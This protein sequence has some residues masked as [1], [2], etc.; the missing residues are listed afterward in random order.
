MKQFPKDFFWGAAT[1]AHQVEGNN[2]NNWS[3][4]ERENAGRLAKEAKD[5]WQDWQKEKFPEMF[6]PENY[7]SGRA[8][9]HYNRYEEDFD[10]AQSSGHNAHRFSIE[11]SRIE[12]EEGKFNEKE[13]EHY[14]KVILALRKRNIEPFATLW[15]WT[16]PL[17]LEEKGGCESKKFP[18]FFSR[19]AQYVVKNLGESVKF[20]ITLNEPTSVIAASYCIGNWP[21]QKKNLIVAW[22][23]YG[24]FARAHI[25]AYKIIRLISKDARVGFAN[26]L[27]SFEPYRKNSWLDKLSVAVGL[28]F[29]NKRMLNLTK[30]YNDFLTVQ[31]YFHNR[32]KFPRKIRLGDKPVNDLNWEIYPEGLYHVL[33][34]LKEY[35]LP[36]YVTENGLADA[37]EKRADFIKNHLQWIKKAIDEG[38]DVRGYFYWSLMDNF[39]WDKGFWP[40]FGLVEIDY[41]TLERKPRKSFYAYEEIIKNNGLI[42][43]VIPSARPPARQEAEESKS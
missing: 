2:V 23:L 40:R 24:N 7:I 35:N 6:N 41:Q 26:A 32:F 16:N 42:T 4:W 19:Y 43:N 30:G 34:W 21:P 22:K 31:Y 29:V 11:W 13:I 25:E 3:Q 10:L 33:K 28:Y 5:K 39:E 8:C 14:R 15:H 18:F 27:H 12:P 37:D 1:S 20:W 17:W 36:I 9:D 38:A